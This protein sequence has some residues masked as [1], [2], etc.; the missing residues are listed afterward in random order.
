MSTNDTI[1]AWPPFSCSSLFPFLWRHT[2]THIE[3]SALGGGTEGTVVPHTPGRQGLGW[4]SSHRG[5]TEDPG[6]GRK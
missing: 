2:P 6:Q 5:Q 1:R 4:G 3:M